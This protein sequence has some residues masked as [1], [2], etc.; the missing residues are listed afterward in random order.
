MFAKHHPGSLKNEETEGG[1]GRGYINKGRETSWKALLSEEDVY[2]LLMDQ[3][4]GSKD[5]GG[6]QVH[7]KRTKIGRE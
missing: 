1:I 7:F 5:T 2:H 6:L 4:F 3:S